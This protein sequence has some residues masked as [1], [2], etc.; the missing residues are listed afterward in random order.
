MVQYDMLRDYLLELQVTNE[1]ETFKSDSANTNSWKWFLEYTGDDLNSNLIF[2]FLTN[3][4][5]GLMSG[6][7][8]LFPCVQQRY[9][10][11]D[12]KEHLWICVTT[13]TTLEFQHFIRILRRAI[14]DVFLN[15]CHIFNRELTNRSNIPL[16]IC[17]EFIIEYLM[18]RIF[19]VIKVI[20]KGQG[21]LITTS[22]RLLK[23]QDSFFI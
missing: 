13:T 19:N 22:T 7:T 15:K 17:L 14:S 21:P 16:I 10:T 9:E 3:R 6:I 1:D 12:Y 4:E 18:K 23:V 8:Q 11:K 5:K 2:A 20:N